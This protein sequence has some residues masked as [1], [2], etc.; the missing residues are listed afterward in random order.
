MLALDGKMVAGCYG[1]IEGNHFFHYQIGWDC[2]YAAFSM[3]N[4]A[5]KNC[6]ELCIERG[7]REY[8]MLSGEYRYK[9]EWCPEARRLIDVEGYALGSPAA[10]CFVGLRSI[11]RL[12][13][14][15]IEV[16]GRVD[17]A[18]VGQG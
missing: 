8:E 4:L 6:V 10:A 1:F 13:R 7:V 15:Q 16:A 14:P 11:K 5:V 9:S 3:G 18:D 12:I 17:E 2:Q